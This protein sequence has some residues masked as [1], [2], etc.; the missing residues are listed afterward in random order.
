MS[1]YARGNVWW[2]KLNFRGQE[3]RESTHSA[4]ASIFARSQ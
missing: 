2:Y 3:I 4:K 1:I